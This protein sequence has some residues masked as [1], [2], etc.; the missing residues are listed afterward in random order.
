MTQNHSD[1]L[2]KEDTLG[3]YFIC[4]HSLVDFQYQIQHINNI[5]NP[6]VMLL[7]LSYYASFPPWHTHTHTRTHTHTN[8]SFK[9]CAGNWRKTRS[10]TTTKC[11]NVLTCIF[12][13]VLHDTELY[14]L[15]TTWCPQDETEALQEMNLP[16]CRTWWIKRVTFVP[17]S[18]PVNVIKSLQN[19]HCSRCRGD[20]IGRRSW[21][22][23]HDFI[24]RT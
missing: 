17:L 5:S 13:S 3:L 8:P 14:F 4:A 24:E 6:N 23:P 22:S 10:M 7:S 19:G 15:P 2:S 1:Q 20:E 12:I 9:A 11:F 21:V 16:K 18:T